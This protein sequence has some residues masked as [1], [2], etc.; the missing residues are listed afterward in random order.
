[1]NSTHIGILLLL[2]FSF[3]NTSASGTKEKKIIKRLIAPDY[4]NFQYAGNLG[5]GS[6]GVGYISK[7]EKQNYGFGYGYLPSSVND[8]E[9]HTISA[10][11][12]FKTL[13]QSFLTIKSSN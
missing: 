4:I 2:I 8:V 5:L 9:V 3:G 7:N 12:A 6:F 1:M 10:K 11:Y 13:Y